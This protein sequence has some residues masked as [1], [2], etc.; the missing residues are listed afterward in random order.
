MKHSFVRDTLTISR[1][2]PQRNAPKGTISRIGP[3]KNAPNGTISRIGPQKNAPKGPVRSP[4]SLPNLDCISQALLLSLCS[5]VQKATPH[6]S[7]DGASRRAQLQQPASSNA[8]KHFDQVSS[9][10]LRSTDSPQ[11]KS[12]AKLR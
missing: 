2:V 1:I 12:L 9:T 4:A 6:M 5:A 8:L 10:V 3:Q 11:R 7:A